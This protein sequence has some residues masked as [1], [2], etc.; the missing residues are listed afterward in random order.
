[1][2]LVTRL[3]AEIAENY[4][5]LMA[6]DKRLENL[7]NIIQLQEQSLR[8]A[9]RL[10]EGTR[11]TELGVQRFRAEVRKNQIERLIV[12]QD[13]IQAENRIT[14]L[15]GRFPMPVVRRSGDFINL[16]LH[17]LS[18]GVPSQLLLN[19]PD[20]RKAERD[21]VAAGLDIK[22]ARARFFPVVMINAGV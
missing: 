6:L 8:T 18:V 2:Y 3:V 19:R 16:N 13:K 14:F 10:K 1:N 11:G 21:L 9:E 4:Y 17:A 7:N 22:V 5:T 20:I 15:A 12:V